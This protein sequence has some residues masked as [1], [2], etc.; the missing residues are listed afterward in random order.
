MNAVSV[1]P[2]VF[3]TD[4]FAAILAIAAFLFLSEILSRKVDRRFS[5]WAWGV[6]VAFIVG[7]RAGHVIKHS[8]NFLAEPL[9]AL[10]IWQGGFL[11][12][13]GFVV[14][15][16]YTLVRFRHELRLVLC[17]PCVACRRMR[18]ACFGFILTIP[19]RCTVRSAAP[20]RWSTRGP[21]IASGRGECR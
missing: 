1:G 21:L 4:R 8:D 2:F 6:T 12:E 7:A 17:P 14:A 3:A 9:R 18:R 10:Y 5:S 13:A 11:I 16:A 19:K 20:G 15:F